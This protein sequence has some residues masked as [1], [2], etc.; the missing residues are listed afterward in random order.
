MK[1]KNFI[2]SDSVTSQK[3][4]ID[5]YSYEDVALTLSNQG[6]LG[7]ALEMSRDIYSQIEMCENA[8]ILNVSKNLRKLFAMVQRTKRLLLQHFGIY[9]FEMSNPPEII[10]TWWR[11]VFN[12]RRE[13]ARRKLAAQKIE[14]WWIGSMLRRKI[15]SAVLTASQTQLDFDEFEGGCHGPTTKFLKMTT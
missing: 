14:A 8:Q 4:P 3:C 9:K 6:Y 1:R 10:A 12:R 5:F 13:F 2:W 7:A 11:R 15:K